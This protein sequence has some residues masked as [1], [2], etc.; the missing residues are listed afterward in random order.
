MS[1]PPTALLVP[2]NSGLSAG[3]RERRV[4][5][6]YAPYHAA[7]EDLLAKRAQRGQRSALVAIHTYT[8]SLQGVVRPWHCG[9]IFASDSRLGEALV[10]GLQEEDG[11]VVGVNEPYAP[12]DRV[13]HTMSRHGEANGN[14]AVMIEVRNDLVS[15]DDGQNAWAMRLAPLLQSAAQ[16][17][18]R[19]RGRG[20]ASI[21]E[22]SPNAEATRKKERAM[23]D[24][25]ENDYSEADKKEDMK[26]LHSMGYAQELERRMSVFSNFAV[27]FSIICILSG[28]IN[29]LAQATAG[30]GGASIGIGWPLGCLISGVFALAMGQIASSYPTAGGLYH[31]S[32]ILGNRFT[33]WLTAWLNL[34]GL[35]HGPGRDQCRHLGLLLRRNRSLVPLRSAS[36]RARRR[37]F[38]IRSSSSR[39]SPASRR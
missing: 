37:G 34:L 22:R 13:Y 6:I 38:A 18:S 35:D 5:E 12:S 24:L 15:D 20:T 8:P 26:I 36:T 32:S 16:M 21:Q 29:S 4:A 28:G 11:L 14:P 30:A 27:S 25:F 10:K 39:R 3:E 33:G 31:W 7:I 19:R 17:S 9:V 2:G 23:T 1:K